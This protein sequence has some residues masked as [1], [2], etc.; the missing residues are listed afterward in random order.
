MKYPFVAA[1]LVASTLALTLSAAPDLPRRA[2]ART[3]DPNKHR[4]TK[5]RLGPEAEK[6]VKELLATNEHFRVTQELSSARLLAKG[7]K[8]TGVISVE[9]GAR[10][11]KSRPAALPRII[12]ALWDKL[13]TPVNA[14]QDASTEEGYCVTTG[15]DDG[16]PANVEANLYV[17][18]YDGYGSFMSVDMQSVFPSDGT[19]WYRVWATGDV[20]DRGGGPRPVS[21]EDPDVKPVPGVRLA[22]FQGGCRCVMYRRGGSAGCILD[23]AL[24]TSWD[25]CS[26]AM[27]FCARGT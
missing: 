2:T 22:R 3:A 12:A 17:E 7:W 14:A 4:A 21:F 1:A 15:W 19:P 9:F 10:S 18:L 6:F 8:R 25:I 11:T 27:A 16:S 5:T 23:E 26:S 24:M 13:I 20:G